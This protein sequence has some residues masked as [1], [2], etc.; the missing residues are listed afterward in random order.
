M[1]TAIYN[2]L[3]LSAPLPG[4]VAQNFIEELYHV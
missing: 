4:G 3:N 2:Y 1:T